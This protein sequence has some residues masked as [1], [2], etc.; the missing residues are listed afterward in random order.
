[1]INYIGLDPQSISR[2]D[3]ANLE[4]VLMA[5][6]ADLTELTYTERFETRPIGNIRFLGQK[7]YDF[8]NG[9]TRD[10]AGE[11]SSPE[12]ALDMAGYYPIYASFIRTLNAL[13]EE[14]IDPYRILDVD[15]IAG[16]TLW[17]QN[18]GKY[19]S[20]LR[21]EKD[22]TEK[23]HSI[24]DREEQET[25]LRIA[26]PI[27]LPYETTFDYVGKDIYI[28]YHLTVELKDGTILSLEVPGYRIGN[29][30]LE[31]YNIPY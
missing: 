4:K 17:T 10:N 6:K 7:S 18:Q 27:G 12:Y 20:A 24:T 8:L 29:D 15:D 26:H 28:S 23:N 25:F 3:S 31:K 14:G 11:M 30:L 21:E 19:P 9:F 16:M 2:L 1:M 13:V 5:Y 22:H